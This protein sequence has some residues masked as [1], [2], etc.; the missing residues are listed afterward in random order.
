MAGPV[1]G[2][3]GGLWAAVVVKGWS[4]L[5]IGGRW[6]RMTVNGSK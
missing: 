3:G 1:V 6:W 5:A 2:G 4:M